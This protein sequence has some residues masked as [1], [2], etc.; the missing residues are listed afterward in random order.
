MLIHLEY[1]KQIT[2]F[3]EENNTRIMEEITIYIAVDGTRFDSKGNC[4]YYESICKNVSNVMGRLR[5]NNEVSSR[6]A[7]RQ[8]I[9]VVREVKQ[10]FFLICAEVIHSYSQWFKEVADGTRHISHAGRILSDYS[11]D[12]PIL[13]NAYFRLECIS[14]TSGIEYEQPYFSNHEIVFN[15]V[16]I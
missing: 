5:Q 6:I 15:G 8:D 7:I 10:D 2:I 1:L 14:E 16:I 3:A 12:F 13:Y 4:E 9:D 11:N